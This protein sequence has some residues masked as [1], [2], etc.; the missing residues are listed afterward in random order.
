[1]QTTEGQSRSNSNRNQAPTDNYYQD[2]GMN[3]QT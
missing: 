1:M 3:Q 2:Y